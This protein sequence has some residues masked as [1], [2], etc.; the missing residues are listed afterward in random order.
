MIGVDTG[1]FTEMLSS[2]TTPKAHRITSSLQPLI[3]TPKIMPPSTTTTK[4][5]S[6]TMM[7]TIQPTMS[8]T[9]E[10]KKDVIH[11]CW[12]NWCRHAYQNNFWIINWNF[13]QKVTCNT[14]NNQYI[15]RERFSFTS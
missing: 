9:L 7:L 2:T 15:C 13:L 10:P 5:L 3:I 6:S 11:Y 8:R 4:P 12:C 14:G 1:N